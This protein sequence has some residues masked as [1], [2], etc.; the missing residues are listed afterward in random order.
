MFLFVVSYICVTTQLENAG[1]EGESDPGDDQ[2]DES[3]ADVMLAMNAETYTGARSPGSSTDAA[4]MVES[5][6]APV[7]GSAAAAA[8]VPGAAV[9]GGPAAGVA[10]ELLSLFF[11]PGMPGIYS[12]RPTRATPY[13][14]AWYRNVGAYDLALRGRCACYDTVLHMRCACYDLVLCGSVHGI[15]HSMFVC[16]CVC[17]H[18]TLSLAHHSHCNFSP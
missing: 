7:A 17:T 12:L 8:P 3:D 6:A 14:L 9:A 4:P 11:V 2:E 5:S 13:R 18:S 1:A 10:D 15:L 16:L